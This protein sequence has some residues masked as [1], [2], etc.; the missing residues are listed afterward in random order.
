MQVIDKVSYD[1][2]KSWWNFFIL[3]QVNYT[4]MNSEIMCYCVVLT[5]QSDYFC[6]MRMAILIIKANDY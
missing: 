5:W 6:E 3:G 2:W 1:K 4:V